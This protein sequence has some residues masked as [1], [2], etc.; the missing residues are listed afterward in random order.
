MFGGE[1]G[2]TATLIT[3][4]EESSFLLQPKMEREKI[5]RKDMRMIDFFMSGLL[6]D[7]EFECNL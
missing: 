7:P 3:E 4:E 5:N 2:Q 6:F 1:V